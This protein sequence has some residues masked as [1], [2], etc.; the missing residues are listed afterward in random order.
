MVFQHPSPKLEQYISR[1]TSTELA[2]V[3]FSTADTTGQT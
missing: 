3:S 2:V 1:N